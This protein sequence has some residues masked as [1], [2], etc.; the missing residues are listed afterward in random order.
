MQKGQQLL[1]PSCT[2]DGDSRGPLIRD[3]N[4]LGLPPT[5]T[6]HYPNPCGFNKS[7]QRGGRRRNKERSGRGKVRRRQLR[8][9]EERRG[10]KESILRQKGA[11]G[12][13]RGE[14]AADPDWEKVVT[15]G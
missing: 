13:D 9:G 14:V 2:A 3:Q 5:L 4:D 15:S 11:K 7:I 6:A 12:N 10:A 8:R 1:L